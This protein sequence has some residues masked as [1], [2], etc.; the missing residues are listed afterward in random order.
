[1]VK[2]ESLLSDLQ[3]LLQEGLSLG[4]LTLFRVKNG[5]INKRKGHIRVI[6]SE[7]LLSDL[8]RLLQE[9]LSLGVLALLIVENG[10]IIRAKRLHQGEQVRELAHKSAML[11]SKGARLR[12]TCLVQSRDWPDREAEEATSGWSGPRARSLICKA[13]RW[14][15]SA[16]CTCLVQSRDWPDREAKRPH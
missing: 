7:S 10:K 5:K 12:Y 1:M 6:R 13:R 9:G 2:S 3:R 15:G 11:A 4:I 8:Q 16:Q 14:K